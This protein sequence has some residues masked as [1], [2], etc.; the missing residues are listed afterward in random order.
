MT[1]EK[2]I[3]AIAKAIYC[4]KGDLPAPW[5]NVGDGWEYDDGQSTYFNGIDAIDVPTAQAA[6][7]AHAD[8]QW[9]ES[10]PLGELVGKR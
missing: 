2:I 8:A 5:D 3:E 6:A 1:R 4:H 7:Q 9:L 10:L